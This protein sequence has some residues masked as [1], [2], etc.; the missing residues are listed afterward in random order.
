MALSVF[1]L[2]FAKLAVLANPLIYVIMNKTVRQI[3]IY[4]QFYY[5]NQFSVP[6]SFH[7]YPSKGLASSFRREDWD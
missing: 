5:E 7:Q 1:P 6:E 4:L 2:Q 3:S